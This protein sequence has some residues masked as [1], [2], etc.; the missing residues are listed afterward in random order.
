MAQVATDTTCVLDWLNDQWSIKPLN[1]FVEAPSSEEPHIRAAQREDLDNN[2]ILSLV[3]GRTGQPIL[4]N[5][6]RADTEFF[7]TTLLNPP[8]TTAHLAAALRRHR[9]VTEE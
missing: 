8:H 6:D 4:E 1:Y 2:G 5:L 9:T 7:A 3:S